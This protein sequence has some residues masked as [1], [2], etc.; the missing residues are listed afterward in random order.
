[1][2]RRLRFDDRNATVGDEEFVATRTFPVTIV[3]ARLLDGLRP[4]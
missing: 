2:D 1:V 4:R 3:P